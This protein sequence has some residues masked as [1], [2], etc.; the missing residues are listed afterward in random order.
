M[1]ILLSHR[2]WIEQ[3]GASLTA[4]SAAT[5]LG[6]RGMLTPQIEDVWRSGTWNNVT[7]A[8][9]DVD[10]GVYRSI[11]VIAFA[12]PRDGTLPVATPTVAIT[13]SLISQSGTDILNLSAAGFT[14]SPWGVWGWRTSSSGAA[15]PARYIRL[16][17]VGNAADTYLQLGR[18]WVGDALITQ[19]SYS[20]GQTTGLRDLGSTARSNVSGTRYSLRGRPFRVERVGLPILTQTEASTL[21]TAVNEVGNTGQVFFAKDDSTLGEGMFGHFSEPP[22]ISR[23][24]EDL[25]TSDFQI[26]ED[27]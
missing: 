2:N 7:N 4:S 10:L 13:A 26:E 8:I 12:A 25:W 5:G 23:Q 22:S 20:Y 6:A 15:I 24:L 19:N 14:L 16:T 9:L 3:S 11:K 1:G 21:I 27:A 18:L 17:F